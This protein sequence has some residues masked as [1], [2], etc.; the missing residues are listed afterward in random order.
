MKK[1]LMWGTMALMAVSLLFTSCKRTSD[2]DTDTSSAEDQSQGEMIYDQVYKQVDE[3]ANTKGLQK[4]G[5]PVITVDSLV[6]PK[7][8]RIYYG[9][10]NYLCNDGSYRRGTILVSWTG[11]YRAQGTVISIGFSDFYQNDN[12]VEGTKT[13]TNNGRNAA[14]LLNFSI[15]VNGK[16]TCADGRTHTWN[17]NR[18]RTWISGETTLISSDDVYEISG[19]TNGVNRN[20]L[21]YNATITKNLKVDLSCEWRITSGIIEIT[22]EGKSMRTIDF[23]NGACDRLITVSMNGKSKTIERRK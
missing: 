9:D 11:R 8:M 7:T 19:N 1:V 12:K 14:G 23:G 4:G 22:P 16:I 5:Y 2:T 10:S 13:V 3:S 17:S 20:G 6:T 15:V 21:S 18:T